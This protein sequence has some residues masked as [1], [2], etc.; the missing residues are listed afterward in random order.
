MYVCMEEWVTGT[1]HPW[2]RMG[3]PGRKALQHSPPL[4]RVAEVHFAD[5]PT[6]YL[7]VDQPLL[8]K[9]QRLK[10]VPATGGGLWRLLDSGKFAFCV[11]K[12][13][14]SPATYSWSLPGNLTLD[15]CCLHRLPLSGVNAYFS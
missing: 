6:Y 3:R 13:T 15:R 10:K 2:S 8:I 7:P 5:W 1:G 4:N 12:Y 11:S 14:A 9:V